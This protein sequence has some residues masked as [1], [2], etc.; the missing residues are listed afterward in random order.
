ME[1]Q[2]VGGLVAAG[3][4]F[5]GVSILVFVASVVLSGGDYGWADVVGGGVAGSVSIGSAVVGVAILIAA[6]LLR[7][8]PPPAAPPK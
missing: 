7:I 4:A 2:G 3:A 8:S 1:R 5:F 6:M